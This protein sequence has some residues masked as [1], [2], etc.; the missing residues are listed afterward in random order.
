[1]SAAG[2]RCGGFAAAVA[3]LGVCAGAPGRASSAAATLDWTHPWVQLRDAR[4]AATASDEYAWRLF[5]AVN[6]PADWSAR[7]ADFRAPLGAD[8]PSVWETWENTADIF[9]ND[10]T[11]P[12]PWKSSMGGPG[13]A[14]AA[15]FETSS[16]KDHLPNL[17][18]I[19]GGRMAP[20]M[21]VISGARRLTEIRMNRMAFDY[22]RA[23]EL[24]NIDGQLKFLA[25][26]RAVSFPATTTEVKAQ[27]RPIDAADKHRYHTLEVVQ[28]DGTKQLYG[29]TALHLVTKDLPNWFWATFEHVDNPVR[30]D[31]DGWLLPSS[32]RFGCVGER[33]DCNRAPVGI[34]LEGGVW[35]YYRLRG[36]LIRYVDASGQPL[37]LANSE[38]E[39]GLQ[40]TSSCITCHARAS[41][42]LV[43][44]SP[45]RLPIFDSRALS[46]ADPALRNGFLGLP[47]ADWFTGGRADAT[48]AAVF[49]PLDFVWSLSKAQPYRGS[50]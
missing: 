49:Q 13:A 10:G 50:R 33:P 41:I 44:G 38:L 47:Q 37:R 12:G 22:I 8:R 31:A 28:G 34:G 23:R 4:A 17:R 40:A 14:D 21:D 29:L 20:L 48:R 26:H 32:D 25:Q 15:R 5:V 42:G 36:T 6:W 18:H 39:A 24:Y 45:V 7:T 46:A 19:V 9:R 16:L 43:A 27:W 3:A 30:A 35:Q 1:M 2:R 11:D